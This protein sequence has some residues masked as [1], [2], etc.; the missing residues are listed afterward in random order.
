MFFRCIAFFI[1]GFLIVSCG[2]SSEK[3]NENKIK[4]DTLSVIKTDTV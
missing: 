2:E 3:Q 1:F 4:T